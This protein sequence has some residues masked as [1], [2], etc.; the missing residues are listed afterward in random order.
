MALKRTPRKLT[1]T[2]SR[3][4]TTLASGIGIAHGFATIGTIGYT[5]RLT[6]PHGEG[7]PASDTAGANH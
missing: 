5:G 4:G 3:L 2:W 7:A 1:E 6:M